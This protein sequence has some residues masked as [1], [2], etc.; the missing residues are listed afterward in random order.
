MLNYLCATEVTEYLE[1]IAFL[2]KTIQESLAELHSPHTVII[3]ELM[4]NF[5]HAINGLLQ[6]AN[7]FAPHLKLED[8][9]RRELQNHQ[10][11]QDGKVSGL[12]NQD[13]LLFNQ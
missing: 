8:A 13:K 6:I 3:M 11:E 7:Q 12:T 1:L 2:F 10:R 5:Q 9:L 4:Y